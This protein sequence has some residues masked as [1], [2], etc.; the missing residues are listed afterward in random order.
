MIRNWIL[1][2]FSLMVNN[3]YAQFKTEGVILWEND[4]PV[5]FAEIH[6]VNQKLNEEAFAYT[7]TN[8]FFQMNLKEGTYTMEVKLLGSLLHTSE[9]MIDKNL[10]L[11]TI[12]VNEKMKQLNEIVVSSNKKL[13]ERKIDRLVFNIGNSV[14][15]S[16]KDL[17]SALSVIPSVKVNEENISIIGKSTVAVMIDEQI[18]NLSGNDLVNFLKSISADDISK[19][20]VITTP[21]AK[22]EAQGNSGMINIRYKRGKKDSWNG[23]V[24][25]SFTKNTY[26]ISTLGGGF[27]YQKNKLAVTS[28]LSYYSGS[29]QITDT[30][31]M[32]F[33]DQVWTGN[34]PRKVNYNPLASF[35]TG[36]D[37]KLSHRVNVGLIYLGG[38]NRLN[39][40]NNQNVIYV[41]SLSANSQDYRIITNSI[42]KEKTPT[43]S[44]NLHSDISLDTI[45]KKLVLNFDYFKYKNGI[46]RTFDF[47]N[48]VD[49]N[50]IVNTFEASKN[51]GEQEI[52][53]YAF[54]ADL[55]YPLKWIKLAYGGK[56]SFVDSYNNLRFY[57]FENGQYYLNTS[58]SN[59]F[60]YKEAVQAVYGSITKEFKKIDVQLGLRLENTNNEGYS[61]SINKRNKNNFLRLFPSL[62]VTYKGS[63]KNNFSLNYSK[64]IERPQFEFLNPFRI[65]QNAYSYVEGNPFLQPS[66]AHNI[67]FSW[68]R[69]QKWNNTIYFSRILNGFQQVTIVDPSTNVQEIKPLNYY[70]SSKIGLNESLTYN[71]IKW[72]ESVNTL[73]LNYTDTKALISFTNPSLSGWN[74]NLSTSNNFILNP[75]K[76]ISAGVNYWYSFAGVFDIYEISSSS[77]LDMSLSFQFLEKRLNINI[78]GNDL[79]SGQRVT[80][81]SISNN[82]GISFRNYYDSRNFKISLSYKFGNKKISVSQ[83]QFG[84]SE[85]KSRV[86]N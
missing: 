71:K 6:F 8:G 67:E 41:D 34:Q 52:T 79:L 54:K 7:D 43:N 72:W 80:A 27:N 37:Y 42:S 62:Y 11:E 66:Y 26:F 81:R 5:E 28:N 53:N 48:Y 56:I 85:E 75:K 10:L 23:T 35:R 49:Q 44:I 83:R 70:N 2:I 18:V 82:T 31:K 39:I 69:D 22:Y 20:E 76:T 38:I 29:K 86:K 13:I 36:I 50:L 14:S 4:K 60:K 73:D 16:G 45:G 51:T 78:Y 58:K 19:I 40:T 57:D 33:D 21:P 77:S 30:N 64:R 46:Q 15:A 61:I 55:D 25:N 74:C 9:L 68:L 12:K 3:I 32:T 1:I 84:N 59:I 47:G 63:E 65:V 24:R 17:Y